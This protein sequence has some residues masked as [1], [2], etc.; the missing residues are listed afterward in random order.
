M[1][2]FLQQRLRT[3]IVIGGLF[4]N[5]EFYITVVFFPDKVSKLKTDHEVQSA[6]NKSTRGVE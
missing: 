5:N 2:K 3:T 4:E 1:G 6:Q